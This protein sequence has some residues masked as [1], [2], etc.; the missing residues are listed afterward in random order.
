MAI[1][2]CRE[3]RP[4]TTRPSPIPFDSRCSILRAPVEKN[5]RFR[6]LLRTDR[7][8]GRTKSG[9]SKS[10]SHIDEIELLT[11]RRGIKGHEARLWRV[12]DGKDKLKGSALYFDKKNRK[13]FALLAIEQAENETEGNRDGYAILSPGRDVPFVLWAGG[14][15]FNLGNADH[16][17]DVRRAVIGERR[18][19]QSHYRHGQRCSKGHGRKRAIQSWDHR[20]MRRWRDFQTT[21]NHDITKSVLHIC[22]D[23]GIAK[24][25]YLQP[26]G[27]KSDTRC[28]SNLGKWR[29]EPEGW[30]W[31]QIATF[32][33]YKSEGSGIQI[34]VRKCDASGKRKPADSP[35][36]AMQKPASGRAA[37]RAR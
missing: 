22:A 15:T 8:E 28:L 37:G 20:L 21:Y 27:H 4:S 29:R 16:V 17:A 12:M 34:E 11:N 2:L 35:V 33:N 7:Y 31:F 19:R 3:G 9:D 1:L 23:Q 14:R 30:S 24:L 13:W 32:L 25:I 6:L 36:P 18:S 5:G 10:E 26:S